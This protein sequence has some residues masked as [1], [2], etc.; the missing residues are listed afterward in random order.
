MYKGTATDSYQFQ[1][2]ILWLT[3]SAN[4]EESRQMV[5]NPLPKWGDLFFM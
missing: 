4:G 5:E 1:E 2:D 3:F